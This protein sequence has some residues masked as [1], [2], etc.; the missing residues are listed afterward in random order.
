MLSRRHLRQRALQALYSYF[1][2]DDRDI[3][4]TERE[5]IS[6]IQRTGSLYYLLLQLLIELAEQ[7]RI[8]RDDVESKFVS[9]S[10]EVYHSTLSDNAVIKTL[11]AN[12]FF[13]EQVK[14]KKISWQDDM[15]A[16][17]KVFNNLRS[18]PEYKNYISSAGYT[19][20]QQVDFCAW[21]FKTHVYKSEFFIQYI[22]E[23]NIY[24]ADA[25]D[26]CCSYALRTIKSLKADTASELEVFEIHK[27]EAD[28]L[29]FIHT[30]L[31]KTVQNNEYFESLI[32]SKAKNWDLERI[33]M[34]DMILMKLMLTEILFLEQVP[35][36]VSLNEYIEIAKDFSSPKSRVFINGIIDKIVADLKAERKILKSG[37]G[38]LE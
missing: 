23:K 6:G 5:L 28:D 7:E 8:H 1:Q 34:M 33:A 9:K 29:R 31:F 4:R 10:P 2:T 38:L 18:T 19:S 13:M 36:K 16:V 37:R 35:V 3:A 14:Q 32:H 15:D 20:Q 27:D 21:L 11:R 25:Y 22:E 24:W 12:E 26:F 17:R 30:L